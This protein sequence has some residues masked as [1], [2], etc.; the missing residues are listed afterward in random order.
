MRD[1]LSITWYGLRSLW[2][3]F[4]FLAVLN[5]LWAVDVLLL[6]VPIYGLRN[7]GMGWVVA[8]TLLILFPLP[9][10]S[11]GLCFVANQ[12]T[13]GVAVDWHTFAAGMRRS[14]A[15]S[16]LVALTNAVVLFFIAANVRFYLVVIQGSWAV[17]GLSG[18]LV[19][20]FFWLLVQLYWFPVLLEMNDEKLLIALRNALALVMVRPGFSIALALI[21]ALLIAVCV[22]MTVPALF[23]L[24]ALLML[25]AN[26]AA[27]S[28]IA[29]ARKQA[30]DPDGVPVVTDTRTR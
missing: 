17:V 6:A 22:V 26:H 29:R 28:R 16:L 4:W 13:R 10:L 8:L 12:I 24:T 2:S 7:A 15:K 23:F 27:R 9:L 25:I 5:L 19:V 14:W 18:W 3:E 21:L 11:A 1:A 30:Y 20:A